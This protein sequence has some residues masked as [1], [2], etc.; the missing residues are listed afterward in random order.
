MAQKLRTV[1]ALKDDPDPGSIPS[2]RM[3]D[4]NCLDSSC[5]GFDTLTQTCIQ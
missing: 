5:M 2:T 1:T 4:N 3:A